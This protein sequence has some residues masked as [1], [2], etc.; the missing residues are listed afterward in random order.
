MYIFVIS[1][2]MLRSSVEG[3]C[4]I[5][6]LTYIWQ[7]DVADISPSAMKQVG[8]AARVLGA[9]HKGIVSASNQ[10]LH[11]LESIIRQGPFVHRN[12]GAYQLQIHIYI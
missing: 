9:E 4:E 7:E 6:I 12:H 5:H 3:K 10:E 2:E 11:K 1:R 8:S